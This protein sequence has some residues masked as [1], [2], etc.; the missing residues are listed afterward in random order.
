MAEKMGVAEEIVVMGMV[1][2][3]ARVNRKEPQE[4]LLEGA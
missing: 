4:T 2:R 3:T 1:R